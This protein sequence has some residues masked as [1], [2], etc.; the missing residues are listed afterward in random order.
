[1]FF[2]GPSCVFTN[3]INPRS[4]IVRKNEFKKTMVR[5][6]VT[7]GANSTIVCGYELGRYSFI[8][9]GATVT[10]NVPEF[11]LFAGTPAKQIGWVS[12]SGEKLGND[13]TCKSTG[14]QYK[15]INEN[16]LVELNDEK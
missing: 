6:G 3:V 11:A 1:M 4:E 10:S 14:L 15:L 5:S 9:A 12:R 13:L 8:A 16:E 7:I 2:C